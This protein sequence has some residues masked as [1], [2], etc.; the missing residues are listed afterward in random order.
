MCSNQLRG[1]GLPNLGNTCYLNSAVQGFISSPGVLKA[2]KD[3]NPNHEDAPLASCLLAL[4]TQA[5][6]TGRTMKGILDALEGKH[7]ELV[8]GYL[9]DG[10]CRQFDS[11]ILLRSVLLPAL[12]T[13]GVHNVAELFAVSTSRTM[14]TN[15][16]LQR[17]VQLCTEHSLNITVSGSDNIE[18]AIKAE[19]TPK[20]GKGTMTT[21][22]V[23]SLPPNVMINI[24]YPNSGSLQFPLDGTIDL[25]FLCG[26][27]QTDL[28]E[29]YGV[30]VHQSQSWKHGTGV[31]QGG[32]YFCYIREKGHYSWVC[33]NDNH[34]RT[35]YS[36]ELAT[37]HQRCDFKARVLLF[38]RVEQQ[39]T[40]HPLA[41]LTK[42]SL[43]EEEL[44]MLNQIVN[45]IS[46]RHRE[47]ID[48]L[49]RQLAHA[50]TELRR[51][52]ELN[53]RIANEKNLM[54]TEIIDLERKLGEQ[55]QLLHEAE[56]EN[57][58]R[59]ETNSIDKEYDQ[60]E[61]S[62]ELQCTAGKKRNSSSMENKGKDRV[63]PGTSLNSMEISH[64]W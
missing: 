5:Q 25:G 43:K 21:Y 63:E 33:Y 46:T 52:V 57:I 8:R 49:C 19:L 22:A 56:S 11:G 39:H 6:D 9:P 27:N 62:E 3:H 36:S 29:L 24:E 7:G 47:G 38:T 35:S 23:E 58:H 37:F 4:G 45:C 60:V 20:L 42:P 15:A 64:C 28:Y 54:K 53:T 18:E 32:H 12:Q 2:L 16:T 41:A 13:E 50:Q 40:P 26:L 30:V 10:L 44:Q 55:Q 51:Q 31:P 59:R 48:M 14:I 61:G 17:R 34:V 1:R